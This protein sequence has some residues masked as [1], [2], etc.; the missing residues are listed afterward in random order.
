M[1]IKGNMKMV[2]LSL[3]SSDDELVFTCLW[4][5]GALLPCW[6]ERTSAP[7]LW[8]AVWR[9]LEDLEIEIPFDPAIP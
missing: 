3:M 2:S 6:R 8:K 5:A 7:P 4:D 1:H 9:F